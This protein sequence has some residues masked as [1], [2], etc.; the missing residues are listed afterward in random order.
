MAILWVYDK[1]QEISNSTAPVHHGVFRGCLV[2]EGE[3]FVIPW[4]RFTLWIHFNLMS[5]GI[6]AHQA[7]PSLSFPTKAGRIITPIAR[8]VVG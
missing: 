1:M 4:N 2:L 3:M 5:C 7:H 6:W 8:V